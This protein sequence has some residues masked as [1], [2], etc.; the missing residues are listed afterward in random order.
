MGALPGNFQDP[1]SLLRVLVLSLHFTTY[2]DQKAAEQ[3]GPTDAQ[4]YAQPPA[5]LPQST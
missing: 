4:G 3:T 1:R 5:E 2:C